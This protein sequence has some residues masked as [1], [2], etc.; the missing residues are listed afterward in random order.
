MSTPHSRKSSE[1]DIFYYGTGK[2]DI[3]ERRHHL[4]KL[5]R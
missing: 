3:Y 1:S 5:E 4:K 2:K